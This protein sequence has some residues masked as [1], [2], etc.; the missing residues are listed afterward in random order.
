MEFNGYPSI[1]Y[2][3]N[4]FF[5][6]YATNRMEIDKESLKSKEKNKDNI[7]KLSLKMNKKR[8]KEEKW[9]KIL[10]TKKKQKLL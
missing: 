7:I 3:Y 4:Y 5:Q 8:E 2:V 1:N 9:E 6:K 10:S